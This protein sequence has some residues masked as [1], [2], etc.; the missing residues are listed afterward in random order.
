MNVWAIIPAGGT[1][2]RMGG[3]SPKQ[4]MPLGGVP[5]LV[6]TLRVF[7]RSSAVDRVVLAVP[8]GSIAATAE[9]TAAHGCS[10]VARIIPGGRQRQDSVRN[11]LAA[12][13]DACDIVVVHD[14]VRPFIDAKLVDL[15]VSVAGRAGAVVVGVP[16][17]DTVKQT[18]SDD[19]I[20]ATL[21]RK[22]LWI[23]QTPQ[24]FKRKIL[25]EA[26]RRAYAEAYCGTDDAS[27]VERLGVPVAMI[28]GGYDN[29]KIT[30]PE[31]LAYGEYLLSK[32][33]QVMRTG[34]GYDSHRLVEGRK[35]I[36]GGV[37][38]PFERGLVGHS[39]ADAL[40][41]AVIDALL[42]AMGQGDI[43]KHF[44][45]T[46]PAYKG[47][48]SLKLLDRIG[49]LLAEMRFRILN[50]DA[51]IILERPKLA[52]FTDSM[53]ENI[54]RSLDIPVALVN[55]KAKT[56]EGM[57][58]VGRGEGVAVFAVATITAHE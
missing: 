17:K 21:D 16:V 8:E 6:H 36:L 54:A 22:T 19:K 25:E 26:Y 30:T 7:E 1:G 57:G 55:I 23:A 49:N 13:G 27:L 24:V 35:L 58:F 12:V 5:I 45:D 46:D 43:G 48:S 28:R 47:I 9:L 34:T 52:P 56:N 50:I 20:A 37:E 53:R 33:R 4:F 41:H 31:D 44:P 29:I 10:K 18:G 11:G 38:I 39:D 14:G 40:V 15:A 3:K 42:G 2:E 51:G 32:G